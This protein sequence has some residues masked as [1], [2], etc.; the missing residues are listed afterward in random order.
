M[1]QLLNI[2]PTQKALEESCTRRMEEL[3]AQLQSAGNAKDTIA[4]VEEEFRT[5][6]ELMY[7]MLGLLRRQIRECS[8][9]ID[10]IETKHRRKSMLFMGVPESEGE[11]SSKIILDITQNKLQLKDHSA[12]SLTCHRLGASNKEYNRSILVRFRSTELRTSVWMM[13]TALKGSAIS[14]REFLTKARQ[15]AFAR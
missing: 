14:L 5:F 4:K 2:E 1:T 15:T 13:K 7:S 11:D 12:D 10:G 9:A 8:G 6:R 3:E